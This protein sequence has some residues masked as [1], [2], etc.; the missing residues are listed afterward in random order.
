[1]PTSGASAFVEAC[2]GCAQRI[3]ELNMF[4]KHRFLLDGS[5]VLVSALMAGCG[6]SA[7]S[8]EAETGTPVTV[9]FEMTE[10]STG[11]S[12]ITPNA[13]V[14]SVPRADLVGKPVMLVIF[15]GQFSPGNAP[16]LYSH[17]GTV[18]EDLRFEHTTPEFSLTS[19]DLAL[20]I[21]QHS[22]ITP[23]IRQDPQSA[24]IPKGGDISALTF[25]DVREGEQSPTPGVIR[26]YLDEGPGELELKNRTP[27]DPT[28]MSQVRQSFVNS[29]MLLP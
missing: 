3:K 5:L 9:R 10:S 17:W 14:T 18:A 25:A 22:E 15:P 8:D 23:E 29:L 13:A 12:F 26:V 4:M 20:V 28:D 11:V 2:T 6:S 24:P 16:P 21:Y 7:S 19:I 1:M 27:A